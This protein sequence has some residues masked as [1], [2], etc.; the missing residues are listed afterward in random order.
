M[1]EPAF[2]RHFIQTPTSPESRLWC[3]V[4]ILYLMDIQ[5]SYNQWRDSL[6]GHRSIYAMEMT[7]HLYHIDHKWTEY[8]CELAGIDYSAFRKKAQEIIDGTSRVDLILFTY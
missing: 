7:D 8:V 4:L 6:N 5:K 3:A 1:S 2:D